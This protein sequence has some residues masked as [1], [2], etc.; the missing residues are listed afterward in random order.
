MCP[1]R[2]PSLCQGCVYIGHFLESLIFPL[3]LI[4]PNVSHLPDSHSEVAR[5]SFHSSSASHMFSG[6]GSSHQGGVTSLT[7]NF[8][9]HWLVTK[10]VLC[11][12]TTLCVRRLNMR[13]TSHA[14]KVSTQGNQRRWVNLDLEYSSDTMIY[15]TL[16]KS[17]CLPETQFYCLR[18]G[19]ATCP[20]WYGKH[21]EKFIENF[22]EIL[23]FLS[24]EVKLS[25]PLR[26]CGVPWISRGSWLE[27]RKSKSSIPWL[28]T[29]TTV[30]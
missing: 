10:I 29:L 28:S 7:S 5:M 30:L 25:R 23:H 8:T 19:S 11:K 12:N 24:I 15:M 2:R 22:Q 21:W 14:R 20:S 9:T 16:G 27:R 18:N 6:L 26:D 1:C 3:R 4:C 13:K 17:P